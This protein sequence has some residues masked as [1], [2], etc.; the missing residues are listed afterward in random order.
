[1][2]KFFLCT[3]S[4][5][6]LSLIMAACGGNEPESH[7]K[8]FKVELANITEN[9]VD[10]KVTSEDEEIYYFDFDL[11]TAELFAKMSREDLEKRLQEAHKSD[12]FPFALCH[13]QQPW[14]YDNLEAGTNY[15]LYVMQVGE[16][17]TIVD[18]VEWITFKTAGTAETT[19][20]GAIKGKFSVGENK[21][22]QFSQGN[23]Q[24]QAS[25]ETWRFAL[26]QWDFAGDAD[27]DGWIDLFGWGTGD[28]P[29][30]NTGKEE[31]FA[32]FTDWGDNAISNGGNTAKLWRTL[33]MDEWV[34]LF[35]KRTDAAH[36]F[37]MGTVNGVNGVILLPDNWSG[38]KF[39][40]TENGLTDEDGD[41]GECYYNSKGTYVAFN[42]SYEGEAW[43]AMEKAGAVFFPAAGFRSTTKYYFIGTQGMYWSK[44][45]HEK[46]DQ[47]Y[48]F[49]FSEKY[50][51]PQTYGRC[52]SGLSV[53]LVHDVK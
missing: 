17:Y 44:T 24:Y 1:M 16:G 33:K 15:V 11:L 53:R 43:S 48:N 29:T 30:K 46:A 38:E 41:Y 37:G 35:F 9:S 31:D 25:T 42:H 12:K 14:K 34:Y 3:L 36:L 49:G 10:L 32:D 39:T 6:A 28:D 51:W 40:D 5:V 22:V 20:E 52:K 50:L 8:N 23:L 18:D 27:K 4:F 21:K 45:P 13:D 2:K 19:P 26:H 47:R 7:L